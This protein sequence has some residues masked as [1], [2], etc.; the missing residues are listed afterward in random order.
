MEMLC[1][2]LQRERKKPLAVNRNPRERIKPPRPHQ[3]KYAASGFVSEEYMAMMHTAIPDDV[4]K[5][6]QGANDAIDVAWAK[7]FKLGA[8]GLEDFADQK[9]VKKKY[10]GTK[11]PVHFGTLRSPCHEK[12]SELPGH[13]RSYK[14]RIVLRGDL[15]KDIDGYYAVFSEQGTSSSHMAATKF[16]DGI[17]R[18]LGCDGEDSDALSAYT[19]VMLD[20]VQRLLGNRLSIR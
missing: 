8:F 16:I 6:I 10:E 1:Q 13:L 4:V 17:A 18:L 11:K 14:G 12:H 2:Q 15:V 5:S 19:Q 9:D 7:L 20:D 3:E